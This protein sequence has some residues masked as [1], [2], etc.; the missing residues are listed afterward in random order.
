MSTRQLPTC[1]TES[2]HPAGDT[3]IERT[4][5]LH[6]DIV[7]SQTDPMAVSSQPVDGAKDAAASLSQ[8]AARILQQL[9]ISAW[10]P[11]AA[12]VLLTTF[13]LQLG[14]IIDTPK[15]PTKQGGKPVSYADTP[16]VSIGKAF[17]D[18][19]HT[20]AGGLLLLLAA[21]V[22]LTMLT[23][24]FAFEAIRTLEGFWGTWGPVE[25]LAAMNCQ[26]FRWSY[27]RH[28]A[29]RERL[30][31][32]AW[33]KAEA[34]LVRAQI[35]LASRGAAIEFT[36]EMIAALRVKALGGSPIKSLTNEQ[37]RVVE[38]TDWRLYAPAD[39]FRRE[40]N[41]TKRL[42][43]YPDERDMLPTKLGNVLR[44]FENDTGSEAI[45]GMVDRVFDRLPFSLKL[46][47]DEQRGRLDVY[48]SMSFVIPLVTILALARFGLHHR[49][50]SFGALTIGFVAAAFFYRA[51][52]ASARYY[53]G[54]LV[55]IAVYDTSDVPSTGAS[56]NSSARAANLRGRWRQFRERSIGKGA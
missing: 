39:I 55:E 36:A 26:R 33:A 19:G 4:E 8:L 48:C 44:R 52:V 41:L 16:G 22:V 2:R 11:S 50:Y 30:L 1:V 45:E 31:K 23:Q 43:D 6:L 27:N 29:R 9:A 32:R 12:L 47:H 21:V 24:A 28:Y 37:R 34:R 42:R 7:R 15:P 25:S 51:A 10:L 18:I 20:H 17:S 35:E 40:V 14:S 49:M 54:L 3:S 53:G 13:V 46:A 5:V 56:G 38:E